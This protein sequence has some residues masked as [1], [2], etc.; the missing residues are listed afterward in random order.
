MSKE[1]A[2][3][4]TRGRGIL[5][6]TD[7]KYLLGEVEYD[8]KQQQRNRR[9]YIRERVR[10]GII[11]FILLNKLEDRDREQIFSDLDSVHIANAKTGEAST[12]TGMCAAIELFYIASNGADVSFEDILKNG[13]RDAEKELT[14]RRLMNIQLEKEF[15]DG[16]EVTSS[17]QTVEFQMSLSESEMRTIRELVENAYDAIE[18]K[19]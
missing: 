8:D 9:R 7:R 13:V 1:T 2:S 19:E 10:N 11:D 6:E 17:E 18:S 15:D 12:F 4:L 5:T 14:G 16:T 3:H